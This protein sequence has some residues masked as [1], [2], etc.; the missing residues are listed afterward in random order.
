VGKGKV[1]KTQER[2]IGLVN[3]D[4]RMIGGRVS[5]EEKGFFS[6]HYFVSRKRG[7]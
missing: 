7:S 6:R 5:F 1:I 4:E 3:Y 2:V